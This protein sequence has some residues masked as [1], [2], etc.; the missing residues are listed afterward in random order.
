MDRITREDN[1]REMELNE[2]LFADDQ[3][4]VHKEV[5]KRQEHVTALD[6]ACESYGMSISL[7]KTEVMC[8]GRQGE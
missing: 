4:L 3:S 8:S 2:L 6:E 1:V 5:G 7:K